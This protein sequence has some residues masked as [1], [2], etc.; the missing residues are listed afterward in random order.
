MRGHYQIR[1]REHL[2]AALVALFTDFTVENLPA[3]GATIA[4]PVAD[5]AELR[6]LIQRVFDL[7]LTLISV[8]ESEPR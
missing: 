6:G 3:G 2:G 5:Q 8:T 7:G 4:G 1:V